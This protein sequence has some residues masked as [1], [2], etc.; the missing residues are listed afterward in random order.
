[1]IY[2]DNSATTYPKPL[3]VQRAMKEALV[4]YGANSGRGGFSM[5]MA[6]ADKIYD[7]REKL[8]TLFN[9]PTGE[10]VAFT[11][12]CTYGLNMAIKGL[13]RGGAHVIISNLEH[14]AVARPIE[15]LAKKGYITY[16]IANY[17]VNPVV[18]VANFEALIT[19]KTRMIVCMH[20]S[21]VFGVL[22]PITQLGRMA[23]RHG[24]HFIVDGAQS[25]GVV[26][27]D[28][29]E[30]CIDVLCV[31]GHKGLYGPMGTGALLVNTKDRFETI[32]E[33]GT[34]S[35]SALLTQPQE[36]P[37]LFESGTMN[38]NGI[39][40]LSA[41]IDFVNALGYDKIQK[42]EYMLI[43]RVYHFLR[44]N[45]DV[46]LYLPE[47]SLPSSLPILSFNLKDYSSEKTAALLSEKGIAVRAGF[48]CAY[49][50]HK[51]FSTEKIGTV[52]VAPSSFT[53][54]QEIATFASIVKTI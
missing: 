15:T 44:Q 20:A 24:L 37:N 35:H 38:T 51:A 30:S 18:T 34:G 1:M 29:R 6:T 13:L 45:N 36:L 9:A 12:N 32:V 10:N 23:R 11:L 7:C 46:T 19:P 31:P 5:A 17:D 49:V 42:H 52:R 28:M 54:Q 43:A 47:A 40:G 53:T 8:A 26:P 2:L 4:Q 3:S 33:G 16:S 50:A 22:F 41:G 27:I 14:N 25:A 39:I 48:H 21:N